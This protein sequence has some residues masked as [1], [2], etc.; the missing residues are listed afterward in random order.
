MAIFPKFFVNLLKSNQTFSKPNFL[1]HTMSKPIANFFLQIAFP[2]A[3]PAQQQL[4]FR[5]PCPVPGRA[6]S[7]GR[8]NRG[9]GRHSAPL[10]S[11]SSALYCLALCRRSCNSLIWSGM[12]S[13]STLRLGRRGCGRL[14]RSCSTLRLGRRS[15]GCL[16]SCSSLRSTNR[17]GWKCACSSSQCTSSLTGSHCS[18]F[19][20]C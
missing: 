9:E 20:S 1:L 19:S 12:R 16:G 14:G 8:R 15:C 13:C 4:G 5:K 2:A 10:G 6:G 3:D 18:F 11:M 7:E 17:L